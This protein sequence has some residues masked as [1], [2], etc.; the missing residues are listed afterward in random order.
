MALVIDIPLYLKI[1][2]AAA[3]QLYDIIYSFQMASTVYRECC[4]RLPGSLNS[5]PDRD[6]LTALATQWMLLILRELL[7]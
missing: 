5:P 6:D 7:A 3:C 1:D 2:L 4:A